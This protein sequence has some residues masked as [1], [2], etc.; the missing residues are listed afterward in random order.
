MSNLIGRLF[1]LLFFVIHFSVFSDNHCQSLNIQTYTKESGLPVNNVYDAVQDTLGYMWFAT[2]KGIMRYDGK[3]WKLF[4]E[5]SGIPRAEYH[6]LKI[7]SKGNLWALPIR[8]YSGILQFVDGHWKTHKSIT[9]SADF[10]PMLSFSVN[11]KNDKLELLVGTLRSGVYY[12]DGLKWDNLLS[13]STKFG[14]I[15]TIIKE[16]KEYIFCCSSGVYELSLD[17]KINEPSL[18]YLSDE[19]PVLN[20]IIDKNNDNKTNSTYYF[21]KK[22]K[23]I[24]WDGNDSD[25]ISR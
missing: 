13:D 22:N 15:Y 7:D 4:S 6:K 17:K 23:L 3:D 16:E 21:L 9:D 8:S 25:Y 12:Y 19:N 10:T 1:F 5:E 20:I 2:D 24:L 18:I 14:S 11:Y